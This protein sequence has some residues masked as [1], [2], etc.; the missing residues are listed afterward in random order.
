MEIAVRSTGRDDNR[1]NSNS[2]PLATAHGKFSPVPEEAEVVAFV[3]KLSTLS[4]VFSQWRKNSRE[5]FRAHMVCAY[6]VFSHSSHLLTPSSCMMRHSYT[7][8]PV[9]TTTS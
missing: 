2:A 3:S 8:E 9:V 1:Q 6:L 5:M 7:I 4:R